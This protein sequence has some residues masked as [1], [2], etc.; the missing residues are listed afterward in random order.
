MK[1]Q[2]LILVSVNDHDIEPRA[3]D[4]HIPAKCQGCQPKACPVRA[5]LKSS[6]A[7]CAH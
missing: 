7:R 5:R 2:D 1:L 4:R 6:K 3:F